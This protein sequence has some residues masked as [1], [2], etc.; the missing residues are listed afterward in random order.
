[1]SILLRAWA[2]CEELTGRQAEL[3]IYSA[4]GSIITVCMCA[5][6][7]GNSRHCISQWMVLALPLA[8]YTF[9]NG[10]RWLIHLHSSSS[11]GN[12]HCMHQNLRG[13]SVKTSA[14][15]NTLSAF[16]L[17]RPPTTL[18]RSETLG[19][20]DTGIRK[21]KC[22]IREPAG[23]NTIRREN[24][25]IAQ[26]HCVGTEKKMTPLGSDMCAVHHSVVPNH[27]NLLKN[28]WLRLKFIYVFISA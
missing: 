12:L 4:S 10:T 19:S 27:R 21:E 11:Q 7:A 18:N 16:L 17:Y 5:H 28:K 1:M 6:S 20:K 8:V 15:K 26:G 24:S 3:W 22:F 14:G 23:V 9:A 2:Q 25:K 13:T